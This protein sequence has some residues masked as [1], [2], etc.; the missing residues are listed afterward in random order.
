[1]NEGRGPPCLQ[2][3]IQVSAAYEYPSVCIGGSLGKDSFTV[4]KTGHTMQQDR[5]EA[6]PP[7][8]LELNGFY[9]VRGKIN[10]GIK[11]T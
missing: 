3:G 2:D 4:Q 10:K 6:L 5:L 11:D 9:S 7:N 8:Q 1:M